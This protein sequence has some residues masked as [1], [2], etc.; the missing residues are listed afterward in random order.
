MRR[1]SLILAFLNMRR[2][3]LIAACVVVALAI[4]APLALVWSALYTNAGLQFAIRH[5][6]HRF[7]GIGACDG[8]RLQ[9]W[10]YRS[11]LA[12]RRSRR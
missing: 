8:S 11:L 12:A 7:A 5:I 3:V 6:P 10:Y 1:L 4:A 9:W 2:A